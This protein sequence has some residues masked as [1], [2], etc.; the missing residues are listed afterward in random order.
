MKRSIA[1]LALSLLAGSFV[2]FAQPA[3][4]PLPEEAKERLDYAIGNWHSRTESIGRDG[5]VRATSSSDDERRF[6][7]GDR[8]VEI[9]V[10]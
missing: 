8:V 5:K 2:T 3:D 4:Q 9:S 6:V 7:I 1:A 10:N